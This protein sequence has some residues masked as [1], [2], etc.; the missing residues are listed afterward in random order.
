VTLG[1][2]VPGFAARAAAAERDALTTDSPAPLEVVSA[3]EIQQAFFP[4]HDPDPLDP[5]GAAF[6]WFSALLAKSEVINALHALNP[7]PAGLG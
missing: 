2:T 7:A 1:T 5:L 3:E 6:L 4:D